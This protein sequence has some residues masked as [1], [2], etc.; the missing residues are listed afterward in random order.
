MS[1][2]ANVFDFNADEM[3]RKFYDQLEKDGTV[4]SEDAKRILGKIVDQD[5]NN[6]LR[7]CEMEIIIDALLIQI[8]HE[9]GDI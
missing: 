5:A 1:I 3:I 2:G 7:M 9:R 6:F 4:I 8:R